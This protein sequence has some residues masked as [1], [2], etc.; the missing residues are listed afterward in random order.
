LF[1][2]ESLPSI[3]LQRRPGGVQ[4]SGVVAA[5]RRSDID[6]TL[7]GRTRSSA[8]RMNYCLPPPPPR[9]PFR[10]AP[11]GARGDLLAAP[12][13]MGHRPR[14]PLGFS[15]GL[16]FDRTGVDAHAG[17]CMASVKSFDTSAA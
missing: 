4:T 14:C 7:R 15:S 6:V 13:G 2:C 5:S 9:N 16:P 8:M 17:D 11:T 3:V 12:M 1:F 10:P